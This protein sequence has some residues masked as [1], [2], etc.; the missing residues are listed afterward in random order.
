[1]LIAIYGAFLLAASPV[2]G[3]VSDKTT[4]RRAPLLVGLVLL[5]GSTG[6]LTAGTS[7]ALWI[8]GR[9]LQG[10]SS[11]V[12]WVT[13]LALLVDTVGKNDVAQYLGYVGMSMS[14]AILIGPLLGGVVFDKGGYYAVFGMCYGLIGADILLR[15]TMI[16]KKVAKRWLPADVDKKQAPTSP[17][18]ST[19]STPTISPDGA[20][21][22]SSPTTLSPLKTSKL[23]PVI[24]L[25]GSRRLLAALWAALVQASLLTAFDSTLP[26][27]VRDIFDWNS[28]GAGLIFLPIAIPTFVSPLIGYFSD[29]YGPRWFAAVGFVLSVPPLV[30]MRLVDHNSM[31]Q[32]VLLCALLALF[33]IAIDLTFPPVMAEIT[34]V[35]DAK[36]RARPGMFGD[37]GAYAQAYG[38]FNMAFAGG[39]LV[40]PL[41]G[42]L[43]QDAAGWSTMT[44]TL[45]L[46]SGITAVPTALMV[47]GWIGGSKE[48]ERRIQREGDIADVKAANDL[49]AEEKEAAARGDINK[50]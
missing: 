3:W 24:T 7:V 39:C 35:V 16:E 29:K 45:A 43:V 33:G 14:L 46:L 2:W 44:W 28:L 17:S 42:G 22:L 1:M 10:L 47:G 36:E 11:A 20:T 9:A 48:A 13:G 34:Y 38:L 19:P 41:W 21:Q 50:V 26:I 37:K 31:S 4:T 27:R 18:T 6:L 30:L 8:V 23:P 25:L 12:V 32:K 15:L 40:G 49:R 5:A